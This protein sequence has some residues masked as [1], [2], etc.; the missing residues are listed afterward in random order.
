MCVSG[1]GDVVIRFRVS[2]RLGFVMFGVFGRGCMNAFG[3]MD[4]IDVGVNIGSTSYH[5][6]RF[7]AFFGGS[8]LE[9]R[10]DPVTHLFVEFLYQR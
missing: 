2:G 5:V 10:A 4:I 8:V 3:V 7:K 1:G 9:P 6:A